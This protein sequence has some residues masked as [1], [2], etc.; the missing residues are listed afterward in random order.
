MFF[1]MLCPRNN[2]P[3]IP[4]SWLIKCSAWWL[5]HRA[6]PL[7]NMEV[8]WDDDYSNG[9]NEVMFQTT[10][11]MYVVL[12]KS[13]TSLDSSAVKGDNSPE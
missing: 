11:Q 2:K 1:M 12:G 8:N 9:K 3:Y 10:N 7:K 4:N 5:S 13:F 6:T